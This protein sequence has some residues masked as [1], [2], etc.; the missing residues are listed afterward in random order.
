MWVG[1]KGSVKEQVAVISLLLLWVLFVN[2][3]AVEAKEVEIA[4]D[5]GIYEFTYG[6]GDPGLTIPEGYMVAV[7]F[8]APDTPFKLLEASF[9]IEEPDRFRIRVFDSNR[10]P[11]PIQQIVEPTTNGW[12]RVD[13]RPFNMELNGDFYIAL[14]YLVSGRP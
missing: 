11:L 7:L 10:R 5:D 3:P 4:Y 6:W 2:L 13:L 1:P 8:T 12:I 9:N 14:E